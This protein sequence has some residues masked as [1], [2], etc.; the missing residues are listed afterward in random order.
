MFEVALTQ[1]AYLRSDKPCGVRLLRCAAEQR[2]RLTSSQLRV[3]TRFR[4]LLPPHP[5]VRLFQL[6]HSLAADRP[7][8]RYFI[9]SSFFAAVRGSVRVR[10]VG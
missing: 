7:T 8:D 1:R 6:H 9:T 3:A 4:S 5:P 10:S 2:R